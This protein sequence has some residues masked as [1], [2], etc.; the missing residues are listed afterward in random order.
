MYGINNVH[1]LHNE[2]Y[3]V[4]LSRI[5]ICKQQFD[6][7][8]K[9]TSNKKNSIMQKMIK[10]ITENYNLQEAQ[11][12]KPENSYKRSNIFSYLF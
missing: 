1:G 6:C 12:F 2:N 5:N 7:I 3:L 11:I 8:K 4:L 10:S 9:Y